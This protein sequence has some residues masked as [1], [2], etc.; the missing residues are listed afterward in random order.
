MSIN[1]LIDFVNGSTG[2]SASYAP[3]R[4]ILARHKFGDLDSEAVVVTEHS[5]DVL[6][7]WQ[8]DNNLWLWTEGIKEDTVVL[9]VSKTAAVM[10]RFPHYIQEPGLLSSQLLVNSRRRHIDVAN[11]FISRY[12]FF[13]DI[14]EQH[15]TI[16]DEGNTAYRPRIIVVGLR[17]N[18]ALSPS[19]PGSSSLPGLG[20]G[21]LPPTQTQTQTAWR[22]KYKYAEVLCELL[23]LSFPRLQVETLYYS[24]HHTLDPRLQDARYA[25]LE[26]VGRSPEHYESLKVKG[27]PAVYFNG[28]HVV[29]TER[30][31]GR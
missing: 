12:S 11:S 27:G 19:G 8:A 28:D 25:S 13:S 26:V 16:P 31:D 6:V 30:A 18:S 17:D 14:G 9:F 2:M 20:Q 21:I 3:R 22:P 1:G 7:E 5:R 23:R 29:Y 10:R 24:V 15:F 4:I